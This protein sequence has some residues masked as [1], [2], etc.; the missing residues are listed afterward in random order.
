MPFWNNYDTTFNPLVE[1]E[2]LYRRERFRIHIRT[3][4]NQG[5]TQYLCVR[6]IFTVIK[7][8]CVLYQ[9][10]RLPIT[11]LRLRP[12]IYVEHGVIHIEKE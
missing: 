6:G 7:Y 2:C 10:A 12:V 1:R 8:D 9:I 5:K 11:A 4:Y 3:A